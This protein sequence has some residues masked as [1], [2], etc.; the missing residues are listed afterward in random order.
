MGDVDLPLLSPSV[1]AFPRFP[2]SSAL[3]RSDQSV[4]L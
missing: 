4:S 2:L 1:S 3:K